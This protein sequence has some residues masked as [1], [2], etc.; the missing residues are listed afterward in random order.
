MHRRRD[1]GYKSR[2]GTT[3]TTDTQS[4]AGQGNERLHTQCHDRV[5]YVVVILLQRLDCLLPRD[6]CLL[7]DQLNVLALQVILIDLLVILIFV[8]VVMVVVVTA[9]IVAAVVD[10]LPLAV[11]VT[12]VGVLLGLDDLLGSG[13]LGLGVEVLDLGFSEDAVGC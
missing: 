3:R 9:V 13:G 5:D 4:R 12:C 10:G 11:V 8:V 1:Y 7:H 2:Q 6:G